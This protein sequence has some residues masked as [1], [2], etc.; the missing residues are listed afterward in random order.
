[1]SKYGD[2]KGRIAIGILDDTT[3]EHVQE[4]LI[5]VF[6]I[7]EGI[8]TSHLTHTNNILQMLKAICW[9]LMMIKV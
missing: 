2:F 8:Y 3:E 9:A 6:R 1:M 7:V 5:E 4:I